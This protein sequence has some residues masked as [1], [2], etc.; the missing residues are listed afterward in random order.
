WI[1]AV[2][3]C[4]S[5]GFALGACGA[6]SAP[7]RPP[8]DRIAIVASE[9]GPEGARLVSIDEHGDRQFELVQPAVARVRDSHPAVS[10]DGKWIVFAS[11]RDRSLDETSL[12][13][14]PAGVAMPPRRLTS[15]KA[16]DSHPTWTP[17]GVGIVFASTRD[18]GNFDLWRLA[19]DRGS[20]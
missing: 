4:G 15:G 13:I 16:I 2:A 8:P 17:D 12:W 3:L 20:P 9:R 18:A 10:P 1:D 19:I 5:V 11:S 6:R 14:V 7:E